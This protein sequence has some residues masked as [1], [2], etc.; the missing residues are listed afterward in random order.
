MLKKRCGDGKQAGKV[1]FENDFALKR[2]L[3]TS[4]S[5]QHNQSDT[6]AKQL[7]MNRNENIIFII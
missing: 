4:P 1:N 7:K 3:T 5:P 2:L 6:K